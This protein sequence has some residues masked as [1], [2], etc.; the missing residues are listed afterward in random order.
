[1]V[2]DELLPSQA[3]SLGH[4]EVK[5]IVTQAGSQTS[6]AAIVARS[7]GIPAVSGVEKI[8]S[9]VKTGDTLVV[10]G[11]EGRV[12]VNPDAETRA[13]YLK[14][15]REFFDF[16]DHLAENREQPAVTADG[17]VL[18]LWANVNSV[19]DAEAACGMGATGVGL[20]RTEYL[21]LSHPS[22]PNEDE[23]LEEYCKIIQASPNHLVTIRTL[24]LGGDKTVPYL[25][26]HGHRE[27]NPFMGWRSIRLSF[28]HPEFLTL[29]L[30]AILRAAAVAQQQ[31]GQVRLMFPMITTLDEIHKVRRLVRRTMRQLDRRG[32]GPRR[33]ADRH[34]VGSSRR[35]HLRTFDAECRRFRVDRLQRSRAV[36]DGRRSGQP[37]GQS[38]L[39]TAI[40]SGP[41]RAGRRNPCLR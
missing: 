31:G 3:V 23:Q 14:L 12:I 26:H 2:A 41:A 8:L 21:Y 10:D 6:H 28:E 29:Q 39:P 11:K 34:D 7:R 16:K 27:A 36:P 37:Q 30:R 33:G 20:F 13:A 32:P 1:M 17:Q 4:W 22:I 15:E 19:S 5:G 18:S 9:H 24:D 25:G 38:P 40:A 35:G